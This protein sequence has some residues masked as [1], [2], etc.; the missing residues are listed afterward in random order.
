MERSGEFVAEAHLQIGP[1]E[2]FFVFLDG[3]HLGELLVRHF[4]LP[5]ER[6]YTDAG[7]V[8]VTIESLEEEE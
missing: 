7:R 6:G 2:R 3:E 1:T 5:R 4:G 8:R